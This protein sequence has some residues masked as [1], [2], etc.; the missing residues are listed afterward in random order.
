[1][2]TLGECIYNP[3]KT[4]LPVNGQKLR[5]RPGSD[6]TSQPSEGANS[7]DTV[8]SDFQ[9]PELQDIIFLLSH[10]AV[11]LCYGSPRKLIHQ[12]FI[13]LSVLQFPHI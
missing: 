8:I 2:Q 11:V 7:S 5:E 10:L 3:R 9:P 4:R 6:S 13:N 12:S 1:M